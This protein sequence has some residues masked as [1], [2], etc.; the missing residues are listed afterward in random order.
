MEIAPWKLILIVLVIILLGFLIYKVLPFNYTPNIPPFWS[1]LFE[2]L[3]LINEELA[4]PDITEERKKELL[5][6]QEEVYN[7]LSK[8]FGKDIRTYL[9]K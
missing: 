3:S 9:N 8:F 1:T 6:R 4:K 5:D 2:E 7:I